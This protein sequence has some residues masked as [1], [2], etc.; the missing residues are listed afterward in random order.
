MLTT[1]RP[2]TMAAPRPSAGLIGITAE[3]AMAKG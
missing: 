1:P 2:G 3:Q